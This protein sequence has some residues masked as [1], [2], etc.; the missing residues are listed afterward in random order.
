M[1]PITCPEEL[2]HYAVRVEEHV[3]IFDSKVASP[4]DLRPQFQGGHLLIRQAGHLSL[5]L[6]LDLLR[7]RLHLRNPGILSPLPAKI[8]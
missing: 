2:K 4:V 3:P 8:G 7:V 6:L 5:L 1:L